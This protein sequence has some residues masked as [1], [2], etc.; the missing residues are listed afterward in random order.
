M[1]ACRTE[2][3]NCPP[4]NHHQ[5]RVDH[6]AATQVETLFTSHP[7]DLQSG[8]S[9]FPTRIFLPC[10]C[11]WMAG[12]QAGRVTRLLQEL[13][14]FGRAKSLPERDDIPHLQECN[15]PGRPPVM[16]CPPGGN[17]YAVYLTM[18]GSTG[19]FGFTVHNQRNPTS[20]CRLRPAHGPLVL[21]AS[22]KKTW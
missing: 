14:P 3:E 4:P 12:W 20:L 9:G 10:S 22:H 11:A 16:R 17:R 19:R 1:H 7:N 5:Q 2:S 8:L 18:S 6:H 15:P 13:I 21:T